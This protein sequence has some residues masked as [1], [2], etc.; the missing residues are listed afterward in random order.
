MFL[1]ESL[2]NKIGYKI[3]RTLK[4]DKDSEEIMAYGAFNLLQ[5]LW[6]TLLIVIFGIAFNVLIEVLIMFFTICILRKYSGGVHASSPGRCT[7]VG[8][9]VCVGFALIIHKLYWIFNIYGILS[10]GAVS[11]IFSYY[12]VYKFAPVDSIAKPIVKIETKK[13]FKRQSILILNV[14]SIIIFVILIFYFKYS[15][16]FLLN[17]IVCIYVGAVW[18]SFT[19]TN[20]GHKILTKIDNILKNF[21]R[22]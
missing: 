17:A 19:L 8:T 7:I 21:V 11:L 3:A 1:I 12:I 10:L 13:R 14:L 6:S 5:V 16:I 4:L 2:S 18:Q 15:N 22:K 20:E 9:T